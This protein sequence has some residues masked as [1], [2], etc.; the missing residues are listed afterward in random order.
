[1]IFLKVL[2]VIFIVFFLLTLLLGLLMICT[3]TPN[4][5]VPFLLISIPGLIVSTSLNT[6]KK[7][8]VKSV[9]K[10]AVKTTTVQTPQNTKR[11]VSVVCKSCG[12]VTQV[13]LGEDGVCD[14]CNSPIKGET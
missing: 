4:V 10:V 6:N 12:G 14:Y 9:D 8:A 5:G 1:M 11:H 7:T 13:A 3:G 2:K